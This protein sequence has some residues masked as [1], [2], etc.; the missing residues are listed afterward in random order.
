MRHIRV[1]V[2]DSDSTSTCLNRAM[3][4]RAGF[5]VVSLTT[6]RKLPVWRPPP[7][8][9]VVVDAKS[10]ESGLD[11]LAVLRL[12][13]NQTPIVAFTALASPRA[14]RRFSAVG[15][16]RV[17]IKPSGILQLATAV[18]EEAQKVSPIKNAAVARSVLRALRFLASPMRSSL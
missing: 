8:D 14:R 10:I 6:A 1:L 11:D 13:Y 16:D 3:L 9:V 12:R 18:A 7:A 15:Y 5:S 2:I 17:L 4:E